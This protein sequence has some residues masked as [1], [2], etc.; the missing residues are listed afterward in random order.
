MKIAVAS[1]HGG[2]EFKQSLKKILLSW[3]H[4]MVDFGTDSLESCDYPDFGVP[5]ARSVCEGSSD[6]AVLICTNGIGMCIA[7]NKLSGI[8][9][10]M[11]YNE[12]TART[13]RKH[14]DSNVICLGAQEFPEVDLLKMLKAWLETEFEGG[15][16]QRRIDK[17][18]PVN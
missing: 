18:P 3:G 14:H 17:F 16:H 13:T 10:A 4:E 2:F 8:R 12:R 7:A 9:A 1:D 6:R 5:A 15:R 11:V